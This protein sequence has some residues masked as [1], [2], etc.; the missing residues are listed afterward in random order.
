VIFIGI[1]DTD[2]IGTPGTN[3]LARA[4][5]KR[6]GDAARDSIIC[7]HQLFFDPRVPYTSH[8]GSAS[9]QLPHS[10]A[11]DTQELTDIIREVIRGW[12]VAGSDP[13][14]CIAAS[15]SKEMRAFGLRCKSEVVTQDEARA[16]A[17][18]AACHLEGLGGTEQGV[19]GALAA[20]G[21]I[22]SGEDGRVVQLHA[23]P[24]PDEEFSG[25]RQID[26]IYARGINEIRQLKSGEPVAKGAVDIGKHLR[27]NWRGGR[28]VLYVD[29]SAD[30]QTGAPW[31]AVKV[32]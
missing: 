10:D 27:P 6:L 15:A 22:S 2:I 1:D 7:R 28:I 20:V 26:E 30:S 5:L 14:L 21:L 19:I 31:R 16:I 4:I 29:P 17:A 25:A 12:F 13:G 8:N 24:Y 23:W 32:P 3:Q 9:I 11:A 18:R